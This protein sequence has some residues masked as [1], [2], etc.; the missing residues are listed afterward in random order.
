MSNPHVRRASVTTTSLL[1]VALT[2]TLTTVSAGALSHGA[3]AAGGRV[4]VSSKYAVTATVP[5]DQYPLSIAVDPV[6]H[7][8]YVGNDGSAQVI[9][10]VTDKVMTT[11]HQIGGGIGVNGVAVDS[12]AGLAWFANG[13]ALA[14]VDTSTNAFV[15]QVSTYDGTGGFSGYLP[16]GV[17]TD[18]LTAQVFTADSAYN[19]GQVSTLNEW[20]GALADTNKSVDDAP[21]PTGAQPHGIALD[22]GRKLVFTADL[23]DTRLSVL[24]MGGALLHVIDLQTLGGGPQ[25]VAYD[26]NDNRLLITM[27]AQGPGAV[28][29]EDGQLLVLNASTFKKVEAIPLQLDPTGIAVDPYDHAIFVTNE[30]QTTGNAVGSLSVIDDRT[31]NVE[32]TLPVGVRADAVAVDTETH[33]V[34]VANEGSN[35]VSVVNLQIASGPGTL[36]FATSTPSVGA[37][38]TATITVVRNGNTTLVSS[39][40]YETSNLTA[41]AG[42]DYRS[43][44]GTLHFAKGVRFLTFS[45]PTVVASAP[46]ASVAL[47]LSLTNPKGGSLAA[48]TTATLT[49]HERVAPEFTSTNMATVATAGHPYRSTFAAIG[50]PRP[51]FALGSGSLPAGLHVSPATG[52]LSG[53]PTVGGTFTFTIKAIN[54]VVPSASTPTLTLNVSIAPVITTDSPPTAWVY[55]TYAYYD[56]HA[57]GI[58]APAF[59]LGT[60]TLPPGLQIFSNGAFGGTPTTTGT[61]KFTLVASNGIAP[62]ATTPTITI[63]VS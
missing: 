29:P 38:T 47:R 36:A 14:E 44:K 46:G 10:G 43:T 61:Y 19:S 17:A 51:T 16:W 50:S 37:G 11:Y 54:G 5:T 48:P 13:T 56:F 1:V 39:V 26:P 34:Y 6:T 28:H 20:S 32:Q 24:T 53:T 33:T 30:N 7:H 57:T 3:H 27:W 59:S 63:T 55:N 58:P 41:R 9:S 25:Q 12:K 4:S 45:V 23:G 2:T 21:G 35:T 49:I 42:R 15:G 62:N 60:G 52:T 8:V 31:L 18:P 40:D 22:P